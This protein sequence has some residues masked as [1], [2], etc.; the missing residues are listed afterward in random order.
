MT[1]PNRIDPNAFTQKHWNQAVF[2][3]FRN[4]GPVVADVS[5][6]RIT[7]PVVQIVWG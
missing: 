1:L 5:V 4:A 7:R 2:M 3:A 6:G